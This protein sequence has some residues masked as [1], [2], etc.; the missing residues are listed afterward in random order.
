MVLEL[1]PENHPK[2]RTVTNERRKTNQMNFDYPGFFLGNKLNYIA[3]RVEQFHWVEET[4]I[5]I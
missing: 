3:S 2:A 5:G 4:E 1:F